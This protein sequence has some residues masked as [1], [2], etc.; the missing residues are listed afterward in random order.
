MHTVLRI[1]EREVLSFPRRCTG[2]FLFVSPHNLTLCSPDKRDTKWHT[3]NDVAF[4]LPSFT[5]DSTQRQP[6]EDLTLELDTLL[7]TLLHRDLAKPLLDDK[8]R[9]V[10]LTET[11]IDRWRQ[12]TI[13]SNEALESTKSCAEETTREEEEIKDRARTCMSEIRQVFN[14]RIA[15]TTYNESAYML[16]YALLSFIAHLNKHNNKQRC[17]LQSLATIMF[18]QQIPQAQ[19][20]H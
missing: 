9:E 14:G 12:M 5:D 20:I 18:R 10:G 1:P 2:T 19:D 3:E 15:M 8:L 7:E 6:K 16:T 17:G 13:P 4:F 11:D